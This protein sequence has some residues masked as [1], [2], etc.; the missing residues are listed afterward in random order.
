MDS[1]HVGRS[2]SP[3]KRVGPSAVR[4]PCGA[5]FDSA[6]SRSVGTSAL[7]SEAPALL[8]A[9]VH[10]EPVNAPRVRQR[11]RNAESDLIDGQAVRAGHGRNGR[12]FAHQASCE[13][14]RR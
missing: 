3:N 12:A 2:E 10:G 7:A 5:C 11:R 6:P 9:P 8:E 13:R 4:V 14:G 1:R